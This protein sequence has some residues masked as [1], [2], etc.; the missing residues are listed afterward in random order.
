MTGYETFVASADAPSGGVLAGGE[1]RADAS[2]PVLLG[3]H[4]ITANH[5]AWS[6]AAEALD[7]VRVVAPDLRGRGRSNALPGPFGL[8][9]HADDLARLLDVRGVERAVVAGHS[10]GGFVAVRFAERHPD[11]VD[12]LVLIDGGLPLEPPE[13]IPAEQVAA[14][15]L[16]PALARLRMRFASADDYLAFWREHPGIG[17]YWNDAVEA[18]VRYDLDGAAPELR[19]SAN[20][21]A[22]AVNALELDGSAGYSDAL[23]EIAVPIDFLRAERGLLDQPQGLY[24]PGIA[25]EWATLLPALRIREVR[26]VNHYSIIMSADGLAHVIPVLESRLT[27]ATAAASAHDDEEVAS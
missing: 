2:G 21:D 6:L 19:S 25:E 26:D 23:A 14:A 18:Y 9:D 17:P 15:V 5:R 20:P 8:V 16:G 3:V 4:G 7:G 24:A 22:I 13:G 12:S 1:W 10:M 27:A 11:R